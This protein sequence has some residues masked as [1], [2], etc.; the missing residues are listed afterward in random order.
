MYKILI[1]RQPLFTSLLIGHKFPTRPRVIFAL[2][3]N[4][5][6]FAI[7]IV[8]TKVGTDSWQMGFYGLSLT[9]CLLLNMSDSILQ[10][11]GIKI[12]ER[13]LES[14]M[15]SARRLHLHHGEVSPGLHGDSVCGPRRGQ[16]HLLLP[17]PNPDGCR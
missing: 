16:H 10:G 14:C 12:L 11:M 5:L 17:L 9:I 8:F 13:E 6:L 7:S 4:V 2:V 15:P 3:L 1:H